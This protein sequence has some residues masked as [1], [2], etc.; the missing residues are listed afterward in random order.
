MAPV[1]A[2][3]QDPFVVYRCPFVISY[4]VARELFVVV[5]PLAVSHDGAPY[6]PASL[7]KNGVPLFEEAS[8]SGVGEMVTVGWTVVVDGVLLYV[9]LQALTRSV[10]V[11][12]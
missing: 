1:S 6:G 7:I 8:G 5:L 10:T 11:M 4:S 9:A 3:T 2:D 12:V